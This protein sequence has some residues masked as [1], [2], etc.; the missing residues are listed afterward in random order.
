ME[1]IVFG[2]WDGVVRV[3]V[4]ILAYTAIVVLVRVSGKRTLVSMNAF[5]CIVNVALGSLLATT[6]LSR[7]VPVVDGGA[8]FLVLLGLQ[9]AVAWSSS[10]STPVARL[11]RSQ[12]S[13]LVYDGRFL[14]AAMRRERIGEA[15][16]LQALR[17]ESIASVEDADALVLESSGSL[18][19]RMDAP[20]LGGRSGPG[21][22]KSPEGG[23]ITSGTTAYAAALAKHGGR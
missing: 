4:G 8:A 19:V 1:G 3:V 22:E 9:F 10:R 18:S 17:S 14:H 7:D 21:P 15:E 11:V 20:A 6:V 16:A 12:P 23:R 2:G 5:D 13:L